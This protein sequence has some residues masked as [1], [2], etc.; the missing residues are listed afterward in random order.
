MQVLCFA[1]L[2][3]RFVTSKTASSFAK[4]FLFTPADSFW[5]CIG[6][7]IRHFLDYIETTLSISGQQSLDSTVEEVDIEDQAMTDHLARVQTSPGDKSLLP[8]RPDYGDQGA[9]RNVPLW[10]NYFQMALKNPSLVLYFYDMTFEAFPPKGAPEKEITIPKGKKLMQ[11]IRCALGTST[12]EGIT[13]TI[14]T[15]FGKTLVSCKELESD[16]LQTGQFKFWAE[17]ETKPRKRAIRFRMTLRKY[18]DIRVSKLLDYLASSTKIEGAYE[19]VL[20]IIQALD[21]ILGH[22]GKFSLETATPKQGKCFPL[23][24]KKDITEKFK[25]EGPK[26]TPGYL[27]GVRGYFASVRATTNTTLVNCNACCGAFYKPGPLV[28]LFAMFIRN[29]NP[30]HEDMKRLEKAIQGL[31]VELTHLEDERPLRTIFGLVRAG[32]AYKGP[33]GVSFDHEKDEKRYTV[34]DYWTKKGTFLITSTPK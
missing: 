7:S 21:I 6:N 12:F 10:A 5:V 32:G 14:A 24:P 8:I 13:S 4:V 29:Q 2:A 25:L 20:P 22:S 26:G 18:D 33:R 17:N 30:S 9:K 11:I 31:R 15:D 34:A 23:H 3:N 1:R 28:D 16:Q 27:Q 19:S